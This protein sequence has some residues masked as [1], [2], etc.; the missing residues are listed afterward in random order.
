M[1]GQGPSLFARDW[2]IKLKLDWKNIQLVQS[3][4]LELEALLDQLADIF[5]LGL[6]DM[7]GVEAAVIPISPIRCSLFLYKARSLP[8][9]L[10]I[11]KERNC[12]LEM[13]LSLLQ[14]ATVQP[15][16]CLSSSAIV[17]GEELGLVYIIV[18]QCMC[19]CDPLANSYMVVAI[20]F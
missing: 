9:I 4:S 16:L 17:L 12:H 15:Q 11:E 18:L 5:A 8:C 6:E 2:L 7:K 14:T 13:S 20:M 1:K 3:K 10:M 19:T